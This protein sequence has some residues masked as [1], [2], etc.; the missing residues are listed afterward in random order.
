VMGV[1]VSKAANGRGVLDMLK[2][3]REREPRA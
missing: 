2:R 3:P 1:M